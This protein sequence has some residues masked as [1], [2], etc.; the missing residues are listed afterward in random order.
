M[1]RREFIAFLGSI[2]VASPRAAVAQTAKVHRLGT[3]TVGP[4]MAAT[5]GPGA[6]LVNALAK[7]G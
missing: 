2:A 1:K 4:P 3:L 6:I 7:R 5:A